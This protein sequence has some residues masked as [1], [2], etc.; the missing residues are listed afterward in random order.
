MS[1][2]RTRAVGMAVLPGVIVTSLHV[3]RSARAHQT[4]ASN[5]RIEQAGSGLPP[6]RYSL[7]RARWR[8]ARAA[9]IHGEESQMKILYF[10]D[11]K[12]GVLKSDNTVVD[13]SAVVQDI[14]HTGPGDL[15]N[16]LIERFS[17]YRA[18]L[19]QAAAQGRGIP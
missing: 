6:K 8:T 5:R 3:S 12:L 10:D 9:Q 15:I 11:F 4:G 19:E 17:S 13:V 16:G 18:K 2:P 7:R 1:M 14:P